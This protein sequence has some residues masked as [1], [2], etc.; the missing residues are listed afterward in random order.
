MKVSLVLTGQILVVTFVVQLTLSGAHY[1]SSFSLISAKLETF[2][3]ILLFTISYNKIPKATIFRLKT[4]L[5][6]FCCQFIEYKY[7]CYNRFIEN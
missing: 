5:A 3:Q 6:L 4:I 1:V 7:A 2:S